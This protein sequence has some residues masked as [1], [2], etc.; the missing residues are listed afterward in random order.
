LRALTKILHE[1]PNSNFF[2]GDAEG[3]PN[4]LWN[5]LVF[6]AVEARSHLKSD[7]AVNDGHGL[8][9]GIDVPFAIALGLAGKLL[10]DLLESGFLTPIDHAMNRALIAIAK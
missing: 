2:R 1:P 3:P 6:L 4:S 9:Q 5:E 8:A 10:V 7:R